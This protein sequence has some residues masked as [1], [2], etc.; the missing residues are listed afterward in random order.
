MACRLVGTIS[1]YFCTSWTHFTVELLRKSD[2]LYP[3]E[4]TG[5]TLM[6]PVTTSVSFGPWTL[7]WRFGASCKL[8]LWGHS[9]MLTVSP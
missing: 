3:V 9:L 5:P 4:G 7:T 8:T 6:N 2:F 1:N